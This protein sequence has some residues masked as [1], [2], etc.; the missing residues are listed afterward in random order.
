MAKWFDR[1]RSIFLYTYVC[2]YVPKHIFKGAG[3]ILKSD[4]K[5]S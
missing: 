1:V 3:L 2:L 4:N 5:E